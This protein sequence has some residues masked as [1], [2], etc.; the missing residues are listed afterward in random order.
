MGETFLDLRRVLD[1][2]RVPQ[3]RLESATRKRNLGGSMWNTR[4]ICYFSFFD[5]S[6]IL[7]E[8]QVT[9][10]MQLREIITAVKTHIYI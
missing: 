5:F 1:S 2:R 9:Q 4:G 8:L 10:I 6:L 7:G 3:D